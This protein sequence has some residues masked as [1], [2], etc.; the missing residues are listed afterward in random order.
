MDQNIDNSEFRMQVAAYLY[1]KQQDQKTVANQLH[2]SQSQVSRLIRQALDQGLLVRRFEFNQEGITKKRFQEIR[3]FQAPIQLIENLRIINNN[4]V[5][6]KIFDSGSSHDSYS[7]RLIPFAHNASSYLKDL[8]AEVN[9]IGVTWGNTLSNLVDA[10]ARR[11]SYTPLRTPKFFVPLCAELL[12]VASEQYHSTM[13]ADRLNEIVNKRKSEH[14]SLSG[15]PAFIPKYLAA[16]ELDEDKIA[17]LWDIVKDSNNYRAIFVEFENE[18]PFI[19]KLDCI[20]T[21]LGPIDAP[22]GP[23]ILTELDKV[24]PPLEKIKPEIIGDIGGILLKRGSHEANKIDQQFVLLKDLEEMW[25]GITFKQMK[26]IADKSAASEN[27]QG[28]IVFAHGKN[29]APVLFEAI[30]RGLVNQIVIDFELSKE[31]E[32]LINKK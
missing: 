12:G 9:V 15:I 26:D 20:L 24:F 31:L 27:M 5:N 8:L 21:S 16:R 2:I 19:N 3:N 28:V 22:F 18:E 29:K 25:T 4:L 17:L 1:S 30:K 13:I 10:L 32:K 11:Y 7:E 6:V 14:L 23:S